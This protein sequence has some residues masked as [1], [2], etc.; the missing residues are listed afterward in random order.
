MTIL[1]SLQ[2]PA[3]LRGLDQAQLEELADEIRETII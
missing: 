2:G 1:S 3:D